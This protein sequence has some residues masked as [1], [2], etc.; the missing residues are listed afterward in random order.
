[1]SAAVPGG[2]ATPDRSG[3]TPR[4]RS[5]STLSG[6]PTPTP[7]SQR[8]TSDGDPPHSPH[9]PS[10]RRSYAYP[11]GRRFRFRASTGDQVYNSSK[12]FPLQKVSREEEQPNRREDGTET[13]QGKYEYV[14]VDKVGETE[15]GGGGKEEGGKL[16]GKRKPKNL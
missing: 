16:R 2:D 15:Y 13:F 11:A 7:R 6:N 14:A 5:D 8:S 12:P 9:S 3:P 4:S 10:S 1:M